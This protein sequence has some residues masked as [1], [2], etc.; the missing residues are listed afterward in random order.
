M[1]FF[2]NFAGKVTHIL[3]GIIYAVLLTI[4][5]MFPPVILRVLL[6]WEGT[7]QKTHV[8]L[9]LMNRVFV[10]KM[11]VGACHVVPDKRFSHV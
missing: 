10:I 6:R 8:E 9:R 7:T 2:C 5:F 3:M 4:L 11:I 1:I